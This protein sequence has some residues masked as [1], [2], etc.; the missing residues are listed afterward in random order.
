MLQIQQYVKSASLDEAYELLQKNRNNQILG[1]M[2]WL[3]MQDRNIPVAIDCSD[4]LSDE[5]I[6]QEDG[7]LIGA[8]TSLRTLETHPALNAWCQNMLCDSVKDIVGVQLRNM[9]T[10]GGS[11][12]S[13]FGFSDVLCAFLALDATVYFHHAGAVKIEDFVEG[14]G[15][16]DILTHVF[17]KKEALKTAFHCVRRSATDLSVLNVA[18]ARTEK[19]YRMVVGATPKCA[20]RYSYSLDMSKEEIASSLKEKVECASNLRGSAQYRK[21]LVYACALKALAAI[22]EDS[23]A[24]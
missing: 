1:G 9:A 15:E 12:Y 18:A 3:K 2:I 20:K 24:G 21:E 11:L 16:R 10:I 23:Y 5:I 6:E 19:E 14:H 8:M 7:F 22:E 4:I 17:V 13:R